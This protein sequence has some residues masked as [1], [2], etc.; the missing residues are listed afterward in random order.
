MRHR[1]FR[2]E[3]DAEEIGGGLFLILLLLIPGSSRWR[4]VH[5]PVETCWS[6]D[7]VRQ[8]GHFA[9]SRALDHSLEA[10]PDLQAQ[11]ATA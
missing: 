10:V 2:L 8:F 3:V 9:L 6:R 4:Y 1:T 5:Q 11:T 7:S